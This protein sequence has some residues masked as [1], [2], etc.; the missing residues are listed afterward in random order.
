[1]RILEYIKENYFGKELPFEY[2]IYMIFFFESYFIS[3]LS[4]TTNTLLGKGLAGVVLQW[5]YIFVCTIVLFIPLKLR[6]HISKILLIFICLVYIPFLFF[7]TAGYDGTA[8]LFVP[9]G[10]F[11]L[12]IFFKG[13]TR[14]L[15]VALNILIAIAICLVQFNYPDLIT[16]HGA[17]QAKLIDLIVAIVLAMSGLAI[18]TVFVSNA[19]EIEKE[20]IQA[21]AKELEEMSNQDA[22]TGTYNRRFMNSYLERE[23]EIVSRTD[24]EICLMLIDIDY[25]KKINDTYGHNFGDEVLV[26]LA[27]TIH[28]NLRKYDVLVRMGGEEFVVILHSVG[29]TDANESAMRIKNAVEDMKFDNGVGIT[30]SIGLVQ[31]HKED[32]IESIIHRA[33]VNLYKAKD[34]GRN[35]IVSE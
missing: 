12:A 31:A 19:Y 8:L 35:M 34:G 10:I 17:E 29:L 15:L 1:M 13:K 28:D 9:L 23:L 33:D 14:G 32:D 26:G 4:A 18:L 11:L 7:Q 22:L 24:A 20:R 25:F 27:N 30:I 3:I 21:M 5:A 16:P 2:R 6:M